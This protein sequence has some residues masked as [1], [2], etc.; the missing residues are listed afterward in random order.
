MEN[1][2]RYRG[3]DDPL[4]LAFTDGD[5]V[6]IDIT[7]ATIFFTVKENETDADADALISKDITSHTD[8]TAGKTS[9]D[10]TAADTNDLDPGTYYYDI[11]YKSALGKIATIE[12]GNFT[13]LADITRR[14]A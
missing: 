14:T 9:I 6:V 11:Q 2:E 10:I 7:G 8:P 4:D 3:D 12:K 1:L 13:I 5:D